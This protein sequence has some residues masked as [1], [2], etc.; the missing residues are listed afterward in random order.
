MK[1][2]DGTARI[3]PW[4]RLP[5]RRGAELEFLPAALE[6]IE[7]PASPAGRAIAGTII[8]FFVAALAW[9]GLGSVDII[10]TAPGKIVPT[11]RSKVVQP[12]ETGV[13][14]AIHVQDGQAVKAGDVLIELDTTINGAERDRY[15]KELTV[16]RLDVA[17]LRAAL[18]EGAFAPPE[19]AA[20]AQV[21]LQRS[22]LANQLEEHQAK[23]ANLDKQVA[24]NEA[25]RGAVA[26]TVQKLSVALP[27]LRERAQARKYLADKE[28]GSRL[29][30]L[31]VQQ[32]LFE[33]EQDLLVQRSR[34][35]EADA[36]LAAL[37]DQRRQADAEYKRTNLTDLA[38][39]EQKAASLQEEVVKAQQHRDLQT[40]T[41]PVDGTVQQL[42]IHTVGGVVTPAQ[43]LLIVVPADSRLEIEAMVPNR[44]IGFVHAGQIAAIKIDTFNFTR[45]G[46][47]HGEVL[48]VSQDAITR[49]K[50][51]DKSGDK[52]PGAEGDTSEPKGQELVYAARVSL[53][54]AQMQVE[55][56]LVDL[57]PG[58]AV[59]VEIK[60]G[61]RRVIEYLLSPLLRYKQ[62]SLRER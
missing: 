18:G 8:L 58:M 11:G 54:R 48:S 14:R 51:Q 40:L 20:P 17:R 29:Q 46:L 1:S 43:A 25:N 21:E 12:F 33:H 57:A 49:D 30:Y 27:L 7:T 38:Q 4:P 60:T 5:S 16:A 61:S 35:I 37:K 47:L 45:Y 56:R 2:A 36:S 31:E 39:A 62:G 52:I 59:T 32:D 34:L 41:A 44:D 15:Q 55:D 42:G 9:A 3:L 19:G 23:L 13:V 50:P 10:A 24:Q 6:I 53:D 22:L 28:V 26:A